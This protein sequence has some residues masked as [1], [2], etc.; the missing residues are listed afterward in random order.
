[1]HHL[2][3]VHNSLSYRFYHEKPDMLRTSEQTF[4][5][6]GHSHPCDCHSNV[7]PCTEGSL[8]ERKKIKE[9]KKKQR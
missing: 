2:Q 6:E 5:R 8:Q 3:K 7:T 1:M 9:K 4:Q